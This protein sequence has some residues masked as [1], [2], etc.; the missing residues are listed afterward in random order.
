MENPI[1]II[2][3]DSLDPHILLKYRN[4]LPYFSNIMSNSPTLMSKSVFPV[5]TIPA[6][7]SIYTGLKPENHGLL[8]VYDIFDPNLSDLKKLDVNRI[9]GKTFWDYSSKEGYKSAIIY[10]MLMYPPWELNGVMIS[11]SPFDKRINWLETE[12]E[13]DAFPESA[14][15][16]YKIPNKLQSLWG[17]FPG[18]K[19]LEHWAQI[20][21]EM[22]ET[23]KNIGMKVFE[24]QKWDLFY[25]YYSLLDIIQHRYWR[26]FDEN[27]PTYPGKTKLCNVILDYYKIFDNFLGEIIEKYPD[28]T[29]M[30]ISDHGHKIR[31]VKTLNINEYLMKKGYLKSKSKNQA[32]MNI[33]KN[34]VLKVANKLNIE[35]W[36]MKIVVKNSKL[37]QMSKSV[38]S[39]SGSID[40]DVS[41]A[42][43]SN[44]A[45]IKSYSY[46]GIEINQDL[47]SDKEYENV[48]NNLIRDLSK[49]KTPDKDQN[50]LNFVKRREEVCPGK[51]TETIFPDVVFELK[52]DYGVGWDLH[53]NLFG[54][55]YDHKVASGGHKKDAVLLINNLNRNIDNKTVNLIDIAPTIMDY[56]GMDWK[57]F[58]LDGRSIF[59]D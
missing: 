44:F 52:N 29:L 37:T 9:K 55:A 5:D 59:S 3:I 56:L 15:E 54:T 20:G 24:S 31:P 14:K 47:L 13:I 4:E 51:F 45:G 41:Q 22:L 32:L 7:A 21:K 10:P 49:L 18:E 38:Y 36:L 12:I 48:I 16:E 8:Y 28:M 50:I 27:D 11:K 19:N 57:K 40:K 23:E 2:G 25:I 1:T 43:L 39:S 34:N 35:H 30:V 6:W 46:G 53:S 58:N 33:V 42:Y 26:Y 17:G